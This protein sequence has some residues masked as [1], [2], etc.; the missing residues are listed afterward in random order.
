MAPEDPRPIRA[1]MSMPLTSISLLAGV[2]SELVVE[3]VLES[4]VVFR[5]SFA[6]SRHDRE[7][8]LRS[9]TSNYEL[10]QRIDSK[11]R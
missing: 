1:A 11:P 5:V 8:L 3:P 7:A 10:Q 4:R 9:L 2:P 6:T